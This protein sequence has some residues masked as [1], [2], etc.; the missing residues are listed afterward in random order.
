[1]SIFA[2]QIYALATNEK[3]D[4]PWWACLPLVTCSQEDQAGLNIPLI[5]KHL[6]IQFTGSRLHQQMP[7]S[8]WRCCQQNTIV[9]LGHSTHE[10]NY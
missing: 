2:Y 9:S 1:V 6:A 5:G 4:T 10:H 3:C 7:H 8:S